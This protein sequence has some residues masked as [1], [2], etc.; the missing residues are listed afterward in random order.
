MEQ[1][2]ASGG[3]A[4]A[5]IQ[6]SDFV[7]RGLVSRSVRYGATGSL[8]IQIFWRRSFFAPLKIGVVIGITTIKAFFICFVENSFC[9]SPSF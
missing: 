5:T 2:V 6:N 3:Y 9:P 8:F 4:V 1:Q 7:S